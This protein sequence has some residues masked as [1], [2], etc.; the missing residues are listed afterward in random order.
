MRES[1]FELVM[2]PS[3]F[4]TEI[5]PALTNLTPRTVRQASRKITDACL[6]TTLPSDVGIASCAQDA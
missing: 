4:S 3:I 5:V 6:I 2:A 1:S